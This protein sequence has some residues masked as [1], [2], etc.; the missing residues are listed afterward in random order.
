MLMDN[1]KEQRIYEFQKLT[2]YEKTDL[3]G[4]EQ[5]LDF[6]LKHDNDDLRNVALTG[7]YGPGKSSIIRSYAENRKNLSFIYVSLA[8]FTGVQ[9]KTDKENYCCL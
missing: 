7:N 9:G 1:R 3:E 8:H 6:V 2:L 4:Y 5:S